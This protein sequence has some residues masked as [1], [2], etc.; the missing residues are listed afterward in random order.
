MANI[1]ELRGMSDD[2]LEEMLENAREEVFNLRFRNASSQLDDYSRLKAVR[3]EIAQLET[4]LRM[5]QIA[6][7]A[8]SAQPEIAAVLADTEWQVTTRFSYED[9][10]WQ[11]EFAD[12]DGNDLASAMVDLNKKQPKSR[13]A[14]SQR[15]QP[16]LVTSYEIAG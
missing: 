6:E 11:V 12:V 4:A 16:R 15:V 2:K 3:R 7:E 9:S 8:A 10:A 5:R 13:K 14:R 1:V